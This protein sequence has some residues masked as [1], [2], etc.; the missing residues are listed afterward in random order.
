MA[1]YRAVANG[2]WSALATWQDN[3]TGSFVASTVLPGASDDVY[4]N[5]FNVTLDQNVTVSNILSTAT[6]GIAA[7]GS[8]LITGST[9]RSINANI[10]SGRNGAF[11]RLQGTGIVNINGNISIPITDNGL[12]NSGAV[13]VESNCTLNH[14]GNATGGRQ[15]SWSAPTSAILVQ[16]ISTVNL[17][18]TYTGGNPSSLVNWI[19]SAVYITAVN[20]TINI[21]GSL[22]GGN[23]INASGL[24]ALNGGGFINCISCI[25]QSSINAPSLQSSFTNLLISGNIIN[26]NGIS[27]IQAYSIK[28]DSLSTTTWR[29]QT[30]NALIDKTLYDV[31]SLPTLP[32]TNNVRNGVTYASGALT[33]TL[34]VPTANTVTDGVVYDNGTVGTAQN[35]A[36]SFLAALS[37]SPDPLAERLRNV[38]T[39]QVTGN[40]IAAAF[41]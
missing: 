34:V 40:Q 20:A 16:S 3:S 31:Q 7:S 39:V 15:L 5:N 18:G 8:I 10:I 33:G 17:T 37:T 4:T 28:L 23:G 30:Q 1:N 35:T 38:T 24:Y 25:F 21:T 36:A 12:V 6:T 9:T 22:V 41:P 11:V 29:F 19:N 27:A 32:T 14:I 26:T 2:N 13:V